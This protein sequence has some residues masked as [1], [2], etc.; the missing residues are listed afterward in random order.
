M[1]LLASPR[2][3]IGQSPVIVPDDPTCE[4][5]VIE[6]RHILR[7]GGEGQDSV[8]IANAPRLPI[9]SQGRVYFYPYDWVDG[10]RVFDRHGRLFSII[11]Q[12]GQGPGEFRGTVGVYISEGDSVFAFD[13]GNQRLTVFS[14]DFDVVRTMPVEIVPF[15]DGFFTQQGQFIAAAA[16]RGPSSFGFPLHLL[17]RDGELVRS[18]GGDYSHFG[19]DKTLLLRRRVAP[20]AGQGLWAAHAFNY[21]LELFDEEG[22]LIRTLQRRPD[23]FPQVSAVP[24]RPVLVSDPP[25]YA[26]INGLQVDESGRLWVLTWI[27]ADEWR[28]VLSQQ[29][30]MAPTSSG[31]W[32]TMIE[33]ID[34]ETARVIARLRIEE[35]AMGFSGPMTFYSYSD[36]ELHPHLNIWRVQMLR[37][38][39]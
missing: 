22:R 16:G 24:R 21:D 19:P 3:V 27:A 8:A 11:G 6:V 2:V 31:F 10:I 38:G 15:E 18:F 36:E 17:T 9:D 30:D 28:D 26:M 12:A 39:G 37:T 20:S 25:P 1:V 4:D 33:V 14:P 5:C 7:L 13:S 32:D 29:R 35:R 34:P 23:W